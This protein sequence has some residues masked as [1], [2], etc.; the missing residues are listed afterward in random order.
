LNAEAAAYYREFGD[1][2]ESQQGESGA[3]YPIRG[4]A[5]KAP[6]NAA[7]LAAVMGLAE[8]TELEV[9]DRPLMERGVALAQ[10]YVEEWLRL[11]LDECVAPEIRKAEALLA[12]LRAQPFPQEGGHKL[13]P[14]VDVYQRGPGALRDKASAKKT[15]DVLVEHRLVQAVEGTR[16]FLDAM[17]GKQVPRREV[18]RLMEG[19]DGAVPKARS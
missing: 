3:L 9:I 2:L 6:E 15:L 11:K 7:R 19:Q 1:N 18:Y 14:L 8:N 12:W 4:I 17:K 5:S 13:F 16:Y 10:W